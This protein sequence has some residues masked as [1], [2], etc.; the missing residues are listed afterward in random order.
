VSDAETAT[1]EDAGEPTLYD[2]IVDDTGIK[3]DPE[4]DSSVD[5]YKERLAR[6]F[7]E[8][9]EDGFDKLSDQSVEWSNAAATITK[10]NRGSRR[11][12]PL[13]SIDGLP[14]PEVEA[15]GKRARVT[16]DGEPK[17]GRKAKELKEPKAKKEPKPKPEP[18]GRD[19]EA[20]RYF[21]VSDIMAEKPD[22]TLDEVLA[23]LKKGGHDYSEVTVG[24]AHDAF[25]NAY[26][27]LKKHGKLA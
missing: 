19:P 17:K 23:A 20:N 22:M 1:V 21:R 18:K 14:E 25:Q 11:K 10:E 15:T 26:A 24:R 13:P 16:D 2:I 7:K 27:A 9:D 8:L 12:K 4:V 5:E 3:Y 6:H